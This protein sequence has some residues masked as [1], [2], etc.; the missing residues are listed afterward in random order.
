MLLSKFIKTQLNFFQMSVPKSGGLHLALLTQYNNETRGLPSTVIRLLPVEVF[1][2]VDMLPY[3]LLNR[4]Q[5]KHTFWTGMGAVLNLKFWMEDGLEK[6]DKKFL[7]YAITCLKNARLNELLSSVATY[8]DNTQVAL[9]LDILK[10]PHFQIHD[11]SVTTENFC[12][13]LCNQ[14]CYLKY[15]LVDWEGRDDYAVPAR[16][17]W[18]L[19]PLPV[20]DMFQN[21]WVATYTDEEACLEFASDAEVERILAEIPVTKKRTCPTNSTDVEKKKVKLTNQDLAEIIEASVLL[22]HDES[23]QTKTTNIENEEQTVDKNV[24]QINISETSF[25]S[26]SPYIQMA[27]TPPA[28][29]QPIITEA[30]TQK[31]TDEAS[32]EFSKFRDLHLHLHIEAGNTKKV[33]MC[34][35]LD[36]KMIK[37]CIE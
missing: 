27:Q 16:A 34:E 5:G 19:P 29:V 37:I 23:S 15:K 17:I 28:V 33:I 1:M 24:N 25:E 31:R 11:K 21:C 26:Q 12:R 14:L 6:R 3:Y 20:Q 2:F 22:C 30:D 35:Q 32:T 36:N 7:S 13:L 4:Q 9:D 10:E 18:R 8:P